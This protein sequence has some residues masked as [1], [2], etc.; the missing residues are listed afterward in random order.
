M[1]NN[2]SY[3]EARDEL[4][5]LSAIQKYMKCLRNE[6]VEAHKHLQKNLLKRKKEI[7][8]LLSIVAAHKTSMKL[9]NKLCVLNEK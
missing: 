7:N 1:K 2:M 4:K 9:Y 8:Y 6:N 3:K 5:T